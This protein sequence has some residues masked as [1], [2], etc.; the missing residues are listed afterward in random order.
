MF[1]SAATFISVCASK[2]PSC[3]PSPPSVP[4]ASIDAT[5]LWMVRLLTLTVSGV[6]DRSAEI[7][8]FGNARRSP[9]IASPESARFDMAISAFRSSSF[10]SSKRPIRSRSAVPAVSTSTSAS[11]RRGLR[12]ARS[13]AIPAS[14]TSPPAPPRREPFPRKRPSP[15]ADF[16]MNSALNVEGS[17]PRGRDACNWKSLRLIFVSPVTISKAPSVTT[18]LMDTSAAGSISSRSLGMGNPSISLRVS[19]R[20]S[21]RSIVTSPSATCSPPRSESQLGLACT[22]AALTTSLPS[23]PWAVTFVRET[24]CQYPTFQDSAVISPSISSFT[25]ARTARRTASLEAI[26][27][28]RTT[29][30]IKDPHTAASVIHRAR[31][32]LR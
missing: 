19:R 21:G 1:P 5:G 4:C 14:S 17:S 7:F 31:C 10:F 24:P 3:F 25:L 12:M 30:S 26:R 11:A 29:R 13:T 28:A 9:F 2:T 23:G 15:W 16:V 8:S 22:R 20:I 32:F 6:A 27:G 18:R